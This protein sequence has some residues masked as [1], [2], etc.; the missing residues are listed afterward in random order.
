MPTRRRLL[1]CMTALAPLPGV[2]R[3]QQKFPDRP[4]TLV[5]PFAPGGVA[6]IT[7]RTVGQ[8][9]AANL[10][11]PV[12][13]DNKPGAGGIVATQAMLKA[14]ADGH[15]LLLMSN[16]TAVSVHLMKKLP[17]DVV[18]DLAPISTLGF[19]ELGIAVPEDSRFKTLAE[20]LAYARAQPGKLTIGTIT[21]GSTQYLSAELFKSRAGIEATVVPY[22]GSP[23]VINALRSGDVDVVFEI[24]GPLLPQ[25][26]GKTIRALA[27]T[28]TAR[29]PLLP[30]VPTVIEQGIKGYTVDSW[31]A[32]AAPAGTPPAA[33]ERLGRAA[34]E[35]ISLPGVRN[36]LRDL[37][38]KAQAG[39]PAELATLLA[40]EIKHWGE[41]ARA[42]KIEPE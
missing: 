41:V 42:A 33:I 27:V 26:T 34:Q 16:A 20:M 22:K 15:T 13:I 24:L 30:E 7:A 40:S 12:I 5:V 10:G 36:T 14:P 8:A 29:F 4:I 17:F 3:A 18:K 1:S 11:Q 2:L 35:A 9:M 38:V 32:L 31:N 6:D 21:V 25:L 39:T 28:G 19:F 23:A 37:G